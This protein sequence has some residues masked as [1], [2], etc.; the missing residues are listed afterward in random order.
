[1]C[2]LRQ[3]FFS[4]ITPPF[5]ILFVHPLLLI[6]RCIL[7]HYDA[8]EELFVFSLQMHGQ[9]RCWHCTDLVKAMSIET[10][11]STWFICWRATLPRWYPNCLHLWYLTGC[12]HQLKT[13]CHQFLTHTCR[14]P[15]FFCRRWWER[16]SPT[17]K[18]N[19]HKHHLT[20]IS[21]CSNYSHPLSIY[22]SVK[23]CPLKRRIRRRCC[24]ASGCC[25]R[26]RDDIDVIVCDKHHHH[27]NDC[28]RSTKKYFAEANYIIFE[29]SLYRLFRG[30]RFYSTFTNTMESGRDVEWFPFF[31]T[32]Q[33]MC[34]T[35]RKR[36]G[37]R[38]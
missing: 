20:I 13:T 35:N 4:T 31:S 34:I 10:S 12:I 14:S 16:T 6:P 23:W 2:S 33:R 11:T 38:Q 17:P 3:L 15:Q 18:H 30:C 24:I 19:H 5:T 32:N 27:V 28:R 37:T 36:I 9:R 25:Y 22:L 26:W 1:M 7:P 29:G 8:L 21:R